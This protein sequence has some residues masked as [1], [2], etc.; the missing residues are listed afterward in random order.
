MKKDIYSQEGYAREVLKKFKMDNCKIVS[1]PV[2]CGMKLS[3]FEDG[4]K[5][6]PTLSKKLVGSLRYLRCTRPDIHF[7]IGLLSRFMEAP[8]MTHL[9]KGKRILC[10]MKDTLDHGIVYSSSNEFKLISRLL[11]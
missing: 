7:E 10:Y 4:E 11:Q 6:D 9:K 3:K 1:T 5:V 8:T 2:E